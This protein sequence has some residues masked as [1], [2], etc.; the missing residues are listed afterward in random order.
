MFEP[1]E[2]EF[3][4]RFLNGKTGYFVCMYYSIPAD[5]PDP[6]LPSHC[7]RSNLLLVFIALALC[8]TWARKELRLLVDTMV[9]RNEAVPGAL[10]RWLAWCLD[11][12]AVPAGKGRP[13]GSKINF[14]TLHF[15][16][17][18]RRRGGTQKEIVAFVCAADPMRESGVKSRLMRAKQ[19]RKRAIKCIFQMLATS[20]TMQSLLVPG[21][22]TCRTSRPGC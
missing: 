6:P 17:L 9:M 7:S 18:A 1:R 3:F 5:G 4:T 14:Q 10:V 16:E 12:K 8:E 21:G 15:A 20:G 22:P 2:A 19:V 11:T 13:A